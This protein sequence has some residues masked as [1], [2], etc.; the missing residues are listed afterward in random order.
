MKP[1][2]CVFFFCYCYTQQCKT[3]RETCYLPFST[4]KWPESLLLKGENV[5]VKW[6]FNEVLEVLLDKHPNVVA[7]IRPIELVSFKFNR[8]S[9]ILKSNTPQTNP[10][11][12]LFS[13]HRYKKLQFIKFVIPKAVSHRNPVHRV[14]L[15]RRCYVT[16]GSMMKCCWNFNDVTLICTLR[17]PFL[18]FGQRKL[19]RQV[20]KKKVPFIQ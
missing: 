9:I 12:A 3:L 17:C 4:Y 10:I 16:I 11:K 8:N 20:C 19:A 13:V 1:A 2:N 18:S 6:Q 7:T 15:W 14:P 5:V